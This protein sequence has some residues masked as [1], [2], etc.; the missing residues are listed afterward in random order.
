MNHS[1]FVNLPKPWGRTVPP[2]FAGDCPQNNR[3]S[4]AL[5]QEYRTD[6]TFHITSHE[7]NRSVRRPESDAKPT[8]TLDNHPA[9]WMPDSHYRNRI[10][11]SITIQKN[12]LD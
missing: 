7:K 6:F 3:H 4:G 2:G 9:L 12:Y 10:Y 1:P 11:L 8:R 5:A